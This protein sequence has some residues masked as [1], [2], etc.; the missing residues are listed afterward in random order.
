MF[1]ENIDRKNLVEE[2]SIA[3]V[4]TLDSFFTGV[5]SVKHKD[6]IG[7]VFVKPVIERF[8]DKYEV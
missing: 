5:F 8:L 6:V 3:I 2:L 1:L 4:Q 7:V